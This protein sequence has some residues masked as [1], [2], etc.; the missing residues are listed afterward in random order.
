MFGMIAMHFNDKI[1]KRYVEASCK[2]SLPC[3]EKTENQSVCGGFHNLG[4]WKIAGLAAFYFQGN[5]WK[6][7]ASMPAIFTENPGFLHF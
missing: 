2:K 3:K 4:Y 1:K 6:L 5:S 7:G